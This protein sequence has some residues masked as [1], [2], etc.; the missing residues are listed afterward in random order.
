MKLFHK[1]LFFLNDGFPKR[2]FVAAQTKTQVY[3]KC[4]FGH[5]NVDIMFNAAIYKS[6]K[7]SDVKIFT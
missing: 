7:G 6:Q 2:A 3:L 1:I 5:I 4:D